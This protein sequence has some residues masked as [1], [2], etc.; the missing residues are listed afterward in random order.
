MHNDADV[1]E[2]EVDMAVGRACCD[3]NRWNFMGRTYHIYRS[4]H[5][6]DRVAPGDSNIFKSLGIHFLKD[7]QSRQALED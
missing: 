3:D 5:D 6:A 1:D 7:F 4:V 2:A